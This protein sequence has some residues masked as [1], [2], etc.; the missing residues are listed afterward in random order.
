MFHR[1]VVARFDQQHGSSDGGA[2]LLKAA[3]K[4]LGRTKSLRITVPTPRLDCQGF[5][6]TDSP[7]AGHTAPAS[8]EKVHI[9]R[10]TTA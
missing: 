3:D 10:A 8:C 2:V 6:P 1:P 4:R 7:A 5:P 9:G